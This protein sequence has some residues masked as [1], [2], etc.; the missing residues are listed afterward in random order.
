MLWFNLFA[1]VDDKV[2]LKND[3]LILEQGAESL[4][5]SFS[6]VPALHIDSEGC[7]QLPNWLPVLQLLHQ[8]ILFLPTHKS[9][10]R[11]KY[12]H[13]R[14]IS[15]WSRFDDIVHYLQ[16]AWLCTDIWCHFFYLKRNSNKK[17]QICQIYYCLFYLLTTCS[18][19]AST[20]YGKRFF[21]N[22]S[23]E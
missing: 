20:C 2:Q 15:F 13:K 16:E 4:S 9:S 22:T 23:S 10:Y 12:L 1:T 17:R 6:S 14:T 7:Q 21:Y 8:L 18:N 3:L 11:P 19:V 5:S